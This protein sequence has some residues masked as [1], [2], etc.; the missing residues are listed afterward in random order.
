MNFDWDEKKRQLNYEKH[1]I[2]FED[3]CRI[4]SGYVF[5]TQ[6][7]RFDYGEKRLIGLGDLDGL[8]VTVVFTERDENIR[9]ISVRTASRE[10][11]KLYHDFKKD[12]TD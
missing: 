7:I 9:L 2:L 3:V 1:G 10:E 4:F 11:R 8:I 12:I 5:K 6:D